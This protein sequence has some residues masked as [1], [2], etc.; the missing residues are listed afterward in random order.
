M[1]GS[2]DSIHEV[3]LLIHKTAGNNL[4]VQLATDQDAGDAKE[5]WNALCVV[6]SYFRQS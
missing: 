1:L 3:R 4:L 5:Y 2:I 6:R